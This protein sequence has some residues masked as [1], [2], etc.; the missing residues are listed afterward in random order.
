MVFFELFKHVFAAGGQQG[1]IN[2]HGKQGKAFIVPF[3]DT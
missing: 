1:R 3:C 2:A